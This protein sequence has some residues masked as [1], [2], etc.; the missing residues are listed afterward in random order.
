M[1]EG[2]DEVQISKV[3]V[4]FI[5]GII[6]CMLFATWELGHLMVSEWF[7]D[8]VNQNKFTNERIV[9]YGIAFFF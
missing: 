7:A 9:R 5:V 3:E 2:S 4:I 8:W 6:G 1:P